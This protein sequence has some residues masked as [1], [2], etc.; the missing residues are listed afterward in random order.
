MLWSYQVFVS[1]RMEETVRSLLQSQAVEDV[2]IMKVYK[3]RRPHVLGVLGVGSDHCSACWL[4]H[5]LLFLMCLHFLPMGIT[6][7]Q[8]CLPV[9]VCSFFLP[10]VYITFSICSQSLPSKGDHILVGKIPFVIVFPSS[11]MSSISFKILIF[12]C[13]HLKLLLLTVRLFL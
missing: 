2:D 1:S 11:S 5:H 3:V 6:L 4:L 12:L 8:Q 13:C 7:K 9:S 10:T